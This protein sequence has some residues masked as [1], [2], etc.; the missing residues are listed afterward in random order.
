MWDD[1]PQLD[2]V[3]HGLVTVDGYKLHYAEAGEGAPLVLLHG[4]PQHWWS[5]R[6]VIGELAERHRVICPDV[7]GMGWSE[8]PGIGATRGHYSLKRL[9]TDLIGLLDALGIERTR[10]AGH[11]WGSAIGYR[12]CLDHPGR[13]VSA[14]MLGGVHPWSAIAPPRLFLRPWHI[15]L[16]TLAGG[17]A[18]EA[19]GV[20]EHCL[21]TW[22]HAGAF[23]D[24]EVA[25]YVARTTTRQGLGATR[26]YDRNIV[27]REIPHFVRTH[28][29]LRLRVPVLHV[30]GAD[31]ALTVGVP[32]SFE[33]YADGMRLELLPE[34]G[35]FLAEERP[36]E[37]LV[38]MTAFY[39]ASSS[40]TAAGSITGISSGSAASA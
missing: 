37:L 31:D 27:T 25:T 28:R 36:D 16:Y 2:G 38:R 33:R 26:A 30:N 6:H 34:C 11:D 13:F 5:W 7:R 12:A 1:M 32:L 10:F 24:A 39:A 23:D 15:Y 29:S 40:T 9:A 3:T 17:R 4:W 35:H 19:L 22:R 20:P 21:R 8:G 18:G 14:V